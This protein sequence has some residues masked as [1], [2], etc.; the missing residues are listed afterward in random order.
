MGNGSVRYG[1]AAEL[2]V[3]GLGIKIEDNLEDYN[4]DGEI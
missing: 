4:F 2:D 1:S 3:Q